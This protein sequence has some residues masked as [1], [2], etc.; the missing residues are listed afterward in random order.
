MR[1]ARHLVPFGPAS[2]LALCLCLGSA[3]LTACGSSGGGGTGTGAGGSGGSSAGDCFDYTG[4]VT[5]TPTVT[6]AADVLPIFSNSCGISSACHGC[7][8]GSTCTDS[9]ISPY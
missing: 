2:I 1:P 3:S 6:F 4:F 9:G 5:T 8:D 7:N